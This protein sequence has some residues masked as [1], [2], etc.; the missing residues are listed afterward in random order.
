MT[1]GGEEEA[2]EGSGKGPVPAVL[3]VSLD[4]AAA[5]A[6][7]KGQSSPLADVLVING[8]GFTAEVALCPPEEPGR[9]PQESK[10]GVDLPP[11]RLPSVDLRKPPAS[12]ADAVERGLRDEVDSPSPPST[13]PAP[14]PRPLLEAL[15]QEEQLSSLGGLS[16]GVTVWQ[17]EPLTDWFVAALLALGLRLSQTRW[18]RE[19]AEANLPGQREGERGSSRPPKE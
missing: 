8:P 7:G 16:G 6:S 3:P 2:Q 4:V 1:Y 15:A 11:A 17:E 13:S 9:V 19:P 14:A 5:P 12:E 10:D 18:A